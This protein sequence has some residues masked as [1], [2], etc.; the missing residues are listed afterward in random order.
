MGAPVKSTIVGLLTLVAWPGGADAQTGPC[1]AI[2][3]ATPIV[4]VGEF[5]NMR[6][7]V[8]HSYGFEVTLWRA[9]DCL[10]GVLASAG[11]LSGDTP[12]GVI[13][14]VK[15]DQASG[16]L[17]F[18]AKLT[19]GVTSQ[20]GSTTWEPS[21]DFYTFDGRVSA[22]ALTGVV[23]HE[24]RNHPHIA[25]A[26]TDVTLSVSKSDMIVARTASSYGQWQQ[27]W[28]PILAARGPKW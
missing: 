10:I 25:P 26:K 5:T 4:Y 12:V 22:T 14:D 28:K 23:T 19:T 2:P 13:Q 6:H 27:E 1:L 3:P 24:Q 20:R 18:A 8:E 11:G 9:G 7:T 15:Y 17:S 21:R 16:R